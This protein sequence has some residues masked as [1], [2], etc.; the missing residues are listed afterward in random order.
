MNKKLLVTALCFLFALFF[1]LT[2][3]HVF[4]HAAAPVFMPTRIEKRL[5]PPVERI[6]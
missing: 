5:F 1:V 4:D 3:T 6:R 2:A